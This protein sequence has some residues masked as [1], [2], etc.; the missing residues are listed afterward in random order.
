[1]LHS[2]GDDARVCF[3]RGLALARAIPNARLV[4][5]ERRNHLM[6]SHEASWRRYIDE[7]CAFLSVEEEPQPTTAAV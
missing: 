5:L 6:L 2:R 4:A 1:V 7:I 3:E